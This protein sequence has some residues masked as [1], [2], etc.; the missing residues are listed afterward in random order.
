MPSVTGSEARHYKT[1]VQRRGE[2]QENDR[3]S[4]LMI[5]GTGVSLG[6]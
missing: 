6:T 1:V 3:N 4:A 5:N 2:Q